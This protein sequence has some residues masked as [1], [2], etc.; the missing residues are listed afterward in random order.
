M[1][2]FLQTKG[3]VQKALLVGLLSIVCIMMVVTLIP[4]NV[5][6][7]LTGRRS[8]SGDSIAR[9]DGREVSIQEV[10]K[11]ARNMMQQRRIPEQFKNYVLPQAVEA[12][13]LQR[14]YLREGERLGL[15]ATDDD[16][17]YEMQHGALSR[18]LYPDGSFIGSDQ[19][20]DLVAAQFNLSVPEFEQALR[21]DL[22][23][24]K[25]RTVIGAGVF[26]SDPE[27]HEEF[28]RQRTRVKFDYAV[29]TT[30]ELEKSVK[31]EDSELRAF[32]E[33]NQQEFANTIPEQ[34]KLRYVVVDP[35]RLP[36]PAKPLGSEL[37]G[38]YRQHA[39]EFRTPESAKVSHILIK[40]PLA[41][42][43]GNVDAKQAAAARAK[44]DEVL[45]QLRG[46][47]DFAALAKKYSDDTAT[48]KIGGSVGTL[49]QGS[50]SA[51]DIE[52][53]AFSIPKGK[54][55][56]VIPTSYGYEIIRVDERIPA[57]QRT[58]EEV[59][60][61][62]QPLVEAAKNQTEAE[63]LARAVE[64]SARTGSLEKAA[65]DNGLTV[66]ESG[67]ISRNDSLPGIGPS[68]QFAEAVFA[69]KPNAAPASVALARGSAVVQ[70]TE[71]KQPSTPPFEQV[72]ER[73]A[74][75]LKL[76][77]AQSMLAQ[78]TQELSD[79]ARASH[80]LRE[81]AKAVGAT[82][83]TSELV[84]PDGQ[85][86]ELG[87]ISN[88]APDVFDMK[89]GDSGRPILLGQKGA[90]IALVEK[91]APTEAEFALSK[92]QVKAALL[93]RKRGEAEEVYVTSLRERLDKQGRIVIDKK[94]LES[95]S[96]VAE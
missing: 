94:K 31:V 12:V 74:S 70:V 91:S 6:D 95:L 73:V 64:N 51:P 8:L 47:G 40:L 55:S 56:D 80:N 36:H 9:V 68:P 44:A 28:L 85:V 58:L 50:G 78:K 49:V 87:Q 14:V 82:V 54:V 17:R 25:L 52:K 39:A 32:Y 77:K 79:K 75:E 19:Y 62:I 76:Q 11:L 22:T 33:K 88:S 4:G 29:L 46:G 24:R 2:K 93:E 90:V 84:A 38:Y 66:Q 60:A 16:L 20:R 81:A 37:D 57:H 23:M 43:D 35:A 61:E 34:R 3:R 42:P 7:E 83:K 53:V 21:D 48:A 63:K 15:R 86:P 41:G 5:L 10:N 13:V 69:M 18:M 72:K 65:A 59:K 92:D 67:F 27:V 1:I 71:V 96:K 26:V 30:A 45:K 89:P